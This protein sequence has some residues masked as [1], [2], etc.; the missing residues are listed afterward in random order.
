[1]KDMRRTLERF[2][3]STRMLPF[4]NLIADEEIGSARL[5]SASHVYSDIS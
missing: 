2:H 1:M 5:R 3:F 4:Y